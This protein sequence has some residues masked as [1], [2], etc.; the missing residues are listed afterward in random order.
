MLYSGKVVIAEKKDGKWQIISFDE[1]NHG[2][3]SELWG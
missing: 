2:Y 1:A 3:T